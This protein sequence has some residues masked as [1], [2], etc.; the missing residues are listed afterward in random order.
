[1][2]RAL[3]HLVAPS[4]RRYCHQMPLT[5]AWCRHDGIELR[6]SIEVQF[7]RQSG[8]RKSGTGF[9]CLGEFWSPEHEQ[10]LRKNGRR[11]HHR[12][13]VGTGHCCMG[14]RRDEL[15]GADS[16]DAEYIE[17]VDADESIDKYS[18]DTDAA[19]SGQ[20]A[21]SGECR[22]RAIE[23]RSSD[24]VCAAFRRGQPGRSISAE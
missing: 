22:G 4:V 6:H 11:F 5:M 16:D 1:M 18:S 17:P 24:N 12:Y 13:H 21:K 10:S 9:I 7:V 15:A 3:V 14:S 23:F 8:T 20:R 2:P 19:Q